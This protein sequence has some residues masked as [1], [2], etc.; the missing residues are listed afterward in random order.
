MK[1]QRRDS[2]IKRWV[3][4]GGD[5]SALYVERQQNLDVYPHINQKTPS[6]FD[7]GMFGSVIGLVACVA[8]MIYIF[9]GLLGGVSEP[10]FVQEIQSE[11]IEVIPTESAI[12]L[13]SSTQMPVLSESYGGIRPP[14]EDL[15]DTPTFTPSPTFTPTSAPSPTPLPGIPQAQRIRLG[16]FY[17]PL[18]GSHCSPDTEC[19]SLP[20]ADRQG[21]L[22]RLGQVAA[23]PDEY[24]LGSFLEV[25]G[26]WSGVCAHRL[27]LA[28][29]NFASLVCDVLVLSAAGSVVEDWTTVYDATLYIR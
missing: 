3:E 25:Q 15:P 1:K 7:F 17:P 13:L 19:E 27:P 22:F 4:S 11:T 28:K 24:P 14:D 10:E 29:C 26:V 6:D 9:G 23:C 8:V 21:W 18:G 5:I 2:A 12:V 16:W 20:L